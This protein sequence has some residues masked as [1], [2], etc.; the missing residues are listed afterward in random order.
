MAATGVLPF[1]L[2]SM[3]FLT[4]QVSSMAIGFALEG[5]G[6]WRTSAL[7]LNLIR[8]AIMASTTLTHFWAVKYLDLTVTITIMFSAPF[9]VAIFAKTV[10]GE[11]VGRQQLA[12]IGFGFVGVI[13]VVNPLG[14]SFHPAML[15]SLG[16]AVAIAALQIITRL[17]TTT[18]TLG[19]QAFYTTLVGMLLCLPFLFVLDSPLPQTSFQWG[20]FMAIGLIF[21][22]GGH[23]LNV[24]AHRFAPAS[25]LAPFMY[26][27]L[28]W[29]TL[30]QYWIDGTLP[31]WNTLMGALI[32]VTSGLYLWNRQRLKR[33]AKHPVE[34]R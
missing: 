3:R 13:V 2:I 23:F 19:T 22:T 1:Y 24:A 18:D 15:L 8:S 11:Q 26:T 31:G 4:G 28:I 27:Q 29:M 7:R 12:A 21:G 25:T 20:L 9:M 30:A 16:T 14:A 32:I 5:P 10:L 33:Q 17:G 34:S 6:V